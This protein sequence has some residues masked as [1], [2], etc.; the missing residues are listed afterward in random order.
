[1]T[2]HK[3]EYIEKI[4]ELWWITMYW[5]RV[6]WFAKYFYHYND[7]I[8][9]AAAFQITSRT[10]VY[11]TVCS[12]RRSKK[13]SKFRL[14]GICEGNSLVTGEFSAQRASNAEMFPFGDV[15][16]TS[17]AFDYCICLSYELGRLL[18]WEV[19]MCFI[20]SKEAFLKFH[21]Q[22]CVLLLQSGH[23]SHMHGISNSH[24]LLCFLWRMKLLL[25]L[26]ASTSWSW[27]PL[28]NQQQDD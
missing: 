13:T 3:P 22:P 23:N 27:R 15:I 6:G 4:Y 19:A 24:D 5:S 7:V 17:D 28:I 2:L 21:S 1:M 11:S 16:M 10:I 25:L 18:W 9:S 14:T 8:L 12:R 26:V 20:Y